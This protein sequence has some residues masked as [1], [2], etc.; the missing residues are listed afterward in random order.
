MITRIKRKGRAIIVCYKKD[1][2]INKDVYNYC[3]KKLDDILNDKD[4][5][6]LVA[7]FDKVKR[8]YDLK[9]KQ[10]ELFNDVIEFLEKRN[11]QDSDDKWG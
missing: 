4:Y 9:Q 2:P 6:F 3:K 8:K 11:L 10:I 7:L 1:D 5:I